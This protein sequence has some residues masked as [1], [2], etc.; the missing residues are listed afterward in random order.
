MSDDYRNRRFR[1]I[2]FSGAS[3]RDVDFSGVKMIEA[4]LVNTEISGLIIGLKVNGVEVAPLISNELDRLHPE[5]VQLRATDPVGVRAAWTLVEEMWQPTMERAA[6]LTEHERQTSVD[7]EWSFVDTLRHLI[8]VTDA[9]F[10]RTVLAETDPYDPLG[11]PPTFLGD[12]GW[13]GIDVGRRHPSQRLPQS[14]DTE[15]QAF[16]MRSRRWNSTISI[17][18]RAEPGARLSARHQPSRHRLPAHGHGRR[19]GPP[20][21]RDP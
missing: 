5:R 20:S 16:A 17:A 8:F 2:D 9:W 21:V 18:S 7:E 12:V 4:L 3:F 10:G 1:N 14:G 19:V 11:L 6:R 15:C 13:L